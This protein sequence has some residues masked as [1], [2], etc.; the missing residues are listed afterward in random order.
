MAAVE[1]S[2]SACPQQNFF[3]CVTDA[4]WDYDNETESIIVSL[5]S[6]SSV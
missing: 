5:Y 3:K 2:K 1:T 6:Y 4:S